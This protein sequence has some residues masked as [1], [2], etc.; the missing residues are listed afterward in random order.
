MSETKVMPCSCESNFQDRIYGKNM[1]VFNQ[2]RKNNDRTY[3]C[4]VCGK[5]K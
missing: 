3:R 5:E 2:T 4:T 1:R